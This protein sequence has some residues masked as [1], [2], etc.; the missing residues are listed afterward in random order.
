MGAPSILIVENEAIVAADLT[1]KLRRLGYGISGTVWR[2]EEAVARA[3]EMRPDL[4]LMDIR[5]AGQL[6]GIEAAEQI[7]AQCDIPVIYLTAYCDP[8]TFQRAKLTAPF[9][10]IL[11]PFAE[12]E[13]QSHI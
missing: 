4:V 6:D 11:K 8:T 9:A 5:L 7:R 10:Y 2:G 13:L 12:R 1:N 3:R